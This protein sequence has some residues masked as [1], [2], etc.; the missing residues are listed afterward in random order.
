MNM[1]SIM[2]KISSILDDAK[3]GVLA[4]V[5]TFGRPHMRWMTPTFVKGRPGT[6]FAV[7]SPQF[8]KAV[9]LASHPEAEWMLQTRAL[10][11]IVNIKCRINTID[12]P[13]IKAEILEAVG[14]KLAV[15]WRVNNATD[16]IILETV[17][18]EA[19]Y[20][21]PMKGIREVVYFDRK[22]DE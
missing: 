13:S 5:D 20:L 3:T 22:E 7:T 12:N 14:K 9:H 21:S 17:I 16:L 10:D 11:E 15:F 6:I 19:T 18:E 4:T 1:H 8:E 2:S